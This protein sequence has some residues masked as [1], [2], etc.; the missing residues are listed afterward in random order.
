M[1]NTNNAALSLTYPQPKT[2][3]WCYLD[4]ADY[5]QAPSF[6]VN[7]IVAH[8]S[9]GD[10]GDGGFDLLLENV[11]QLPA[12]VCGVFISWVN[13]PDTANVPAWSWGMDDANI[14]LKSIVFK[15]PID[16]CWVEVRAYLTGNIA[17]LPPFGSV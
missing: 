15:G 6:G 8:A 11:G 13:L 10:G 12:A 1:S 2:I 9:V 3:A 4:G 14:I 5:S 17:G 7:G 16:Q